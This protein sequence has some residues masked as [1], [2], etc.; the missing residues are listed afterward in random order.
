M[1]T[2][3]GGSFTNEDLRQAKELADTV[4]QNTAANLSGDLPSALPVR[5]ISCM[6]ILADSL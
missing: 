1:V 5:S 4:A 3:R 2:I 6:C